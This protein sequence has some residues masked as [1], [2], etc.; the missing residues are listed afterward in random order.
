MLVQH[1]LLTRR[2][3]SLCIMFTTYQDSMALPSIHYLLGGQFSS[4]EPSQ[5]CGMPSHLPCIGRQLPSLQV[6]SSVLHPAQ[7][8]SSVRQDSSWTCITGVLMQGEML[9]GLIVLGCCQVFGV[10]TDALLHN[11]YCGSLYLQRYC[12]L[13]VPQLK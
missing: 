11:E 3:S 6:H 9:V 10:I 4:S 2:T 8:C 1:L 7:Y 12:Y 13:V 5:H